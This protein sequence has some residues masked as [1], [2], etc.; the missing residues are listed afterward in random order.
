MASRS[1]TVLAATG[2]VVCISAASFGA[3]QGHSDRTTSLKHASDA[4]LLRF[5]AKGKSEFYREYE[6]QIGT[7]LPHDFWTVDP[8]SAALGLVE[9]NRTKEH[10]AA[11]TLVADE[12][13]EAGPPARCTIM[14]STFSPRCYN[15][16]DSHYFLRIDPAESYLAYA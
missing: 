16:V 12:R 5:M 13:D 11:Y 3:E 7:Q 15:A 1:L 8:K 14:L 2:A 6:T 9:A 10:R 4:E